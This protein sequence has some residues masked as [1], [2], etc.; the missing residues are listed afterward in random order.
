MQSGVETREGSRMPKAHRR[1]QITYYQRQR[2]DKEQ[3]T[4]ALRHAL[5]IAV[6]GAG[7][8]STYIRQ[9][10]ERQAGEGKRVAVTTTTHIYNPCVQY[11]IRESWSGDEAEPVAVV[12]GVAYFGRLQGMDGQPEDTQQSWK[13]GPVSPDAFRQICSRYDVVYVEADGSHSMP[14]KIPL[15]GEPVLPLGTD[16][17]VIVMGR[18]AVGRPSRAVCQHYDAARFETAARS[19]GSSPASERGTRAGGSPASDRLV[20]AES[21]PVSDGSEASV[22][23]IAADS[24]KVAGGIT[25]PEDQEPQTPLT[26]AQLRH[27]AEACYIRPLR[28]R[29][30]WIRSTYYLSDMYRLG[31]K[32][33]VTDVTFILMASGFGRRYSGSENKLLADFHGRPLYLHALEHLKKSVQ[34]LRSYQVYVRTGVVTRYPEI[35]QQTADMQDPDI[36]YLENHMAEEGITSS[37]RIGTR[38]AIADHAQLAVF[39]AADMPYLDAGQITRFVC[40]CICSGKPYGCMAVRDETERTVTTT[41]PGAFRLDKGQAADRLLALHG[42]RGAM[43]LIRQR[44]WDTYYFYTEPSSIRD[45]DQKKDSR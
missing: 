30:P 14:A 26:E 21:S 35:M 44:P 2:R 24:L 19:G 23:D 20:A 4:G 33:H 27:L 28:I 13:L 15:E 32:E 9:Q 43:R 5:V 11:G 36:T 31:E 7:G 40:D 8:K 37:I 38:K 17:V 6:A 34:Q 18:Q 39:F 12:R 1:K 22:R 42:D 16:E 45:I 29:Y 25:A 41:V 3:E 10:A